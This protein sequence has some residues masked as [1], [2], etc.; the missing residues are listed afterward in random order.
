MALIL[1]END[2]KALRV[3]D[4]GTG[5]GSIVISLALARPTWWVCQRDVSEEALALVK[6]AKQLEAVLALHMSDVLT[7]LWSL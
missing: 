1:E 2:E 3:L 5:S 6:N 7:N 4:I